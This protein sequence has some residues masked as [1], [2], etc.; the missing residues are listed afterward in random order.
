MNRSSKVHRITLTAILMAVILLMSFTPLGYLRVGIVSITFLAIPVVIGAILLGPLY[1]GLL[2]AVFGLTS[3]AQCFMGDVLGG[4][5]VAENV[6]FAFVVCVVSRTLAGLLC[7]LIFKAFKGSHKV[8][9]VLVANLAASLLNTLL[10][11]GFLALLYFN[12]SFTPEQV[13]A[14]GGLGSA[15]T[16]VIVTATSINAPIELALCGVVGTAVSKAVL[17]INS[18]RIA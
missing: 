15:L 12:L 8:G 7:G 9:P 16:V 2:G 17:K 6:F 14:L 3:F 4:I 5:L 18:T 10:F 13:E 11:L 1:G